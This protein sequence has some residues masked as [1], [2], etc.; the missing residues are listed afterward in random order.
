VLYND[1]IHRVQNYSHDLTDEESREALELMVVALCT[2]LRDE[3]RKEFAA[4]L[5]TELQNIALIVQKTE[6][7]TRKNLLKQF[8]DLQKID[9]SHA[10]EQIKAAW[11]ALRDAVS[12]REIEEVKSQLPPRTTALLS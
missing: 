8:M 7:D 10:K 1:L 2:R 6:S 9:E 4:E 3:E 11:C 12:R 5:P